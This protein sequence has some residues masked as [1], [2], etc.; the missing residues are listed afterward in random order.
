MTPRLDNWSSCVRSA[1]PYL[2]PEMCRT[3]L[4]GTVTGDR[5]FADGAHVVTSPIV[6]VVKARG[7]VVTRTGTE[8]RLG[9]VDRAY[10]RLYPNARKRLFANLPE[11]GA[12]HAS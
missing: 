5:R 10:A 1:N 2:A 9:R 11:K 6:G 12:L 8:Y 3:C 7:T 4:Q